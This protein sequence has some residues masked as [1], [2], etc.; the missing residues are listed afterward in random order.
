MVQESAVPPWTMLLFV[1]SMDSDLW[2]E[3]GGS[4]EEKAGIS[5]NRARCRWS[6]LCLAYSGHIGVAA[7]RST[8]VRKLFGFA[9]VD[10]RCT[11]V[12]ID[13]IKGVALSIEARGSMHISIIY[14]LPFDL[15]VQIYGKNKPTAVMIVVVCQSLLTYGKSLYMYV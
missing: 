9:E 5:D 10:R 8:V 14:A 1:A 4:A 15:L 12:Y 13:G 7:Q 6:A 2:S 11:T 3:E